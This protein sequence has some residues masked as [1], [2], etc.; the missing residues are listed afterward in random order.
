MTGTSITATKTR[1]NAYSTKPYPFSFGAK[2]MDI[3]LLSFVGFFYNQA[4]TIP[5]GSGKTAQTSKWTESFFKIFQCFCRD[6]SGITASVNIFPASKPMGSPLLWTL[7]A[8]LYWLFYQISS[9]IAIY[10]HIFKRRVL[11]AS[12]VRCWMSGC[13]FSGRLDSPLSTVWLWFD[14]STVSL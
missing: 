5:S 3:H 4:G 7:N 6:L 2:G 12:R 9:G 14:S 10:F 13:R 1:I 11:R 8:V